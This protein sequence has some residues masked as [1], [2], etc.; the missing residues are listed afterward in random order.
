VGL[1]TRASALLIARPARRLGK[2]RAADL[3]ADLLGLRAQLL[4]NSDQ[5]RC[6]YD[7][8][9]HVPQLH[10]VERAGERNEHKQQTGQN[11]RHGGD[12]YIDPRHE[13]GDDLE[14]RGECRLD[15]VPAELVEMFV[16]QLSAQA[17]VRHRLQHFSIHHIDRRALCVGGDLIEDLSK[18]DFVFLARDVANVRRADDVVHA[19]QRVVRVT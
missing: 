11:E 9:E 3:A 16:L 6:Q 13:A 4:A 12:R 2:Q 17:M 15:Q 1:F 8:D 19:E 14:G 7:P 18:L 10:K 5:Q